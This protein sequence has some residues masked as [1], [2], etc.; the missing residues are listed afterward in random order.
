MVTSSIC[1]NAFR[2]QVCILISSLV[3]RVSLRA[4]NRLRDKTTLETLNY[5]N[6][7]GWIGIPI[8]RWISTKINDK[9]CILFFN[10]CEKFHAKKF[11]GDYF[12]M[13]TVYTVAGCQCKTWTR[14]TSLTFERLKT[15]KNKL[16]RTNAHSPVVNVGASDIIIIISSSNSS[17]DNNNSS[18]RSPRAIVTSR[19]SVVDAWCGL[20]A[21]K[22]ATCPEVF[23]QSTVITSI[24]VHRT[25]VSKRCITNNSTDVDITIIMF[26]RTPGLY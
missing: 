17:N 24:I 21:T 7:L 12:F 5:G 23:W 6:C 1:S 4:A 16:T 10:S 13:F 14:T 18:M 3:N 26:I 2:L 11:A 9:I 8:F 22:R 19:A 25:A 15:H 20:L